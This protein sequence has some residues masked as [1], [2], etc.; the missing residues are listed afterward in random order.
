MC[1]SLVS[2]HLQKQSTN[3]IERNPSPG[4][5]GLLFVICRFGEKGGRGKRGEK[6]RGICEGGSSS[7]RRVGFCRSKCVL[8]HLRMSVW[9]SPWKMPARWAIYAVPIVYRPNSLLYQNIVCLACILYCGAA[10]TSSV[11]LYIHFANVCLYIH[12]ASVCIHRLAM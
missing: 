8:Q 3:M 11:C 5:G 7:S 2:A 6:Q 4:G 1:F 10:K 12:F 9:K